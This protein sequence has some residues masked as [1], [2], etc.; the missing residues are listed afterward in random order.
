[1]FKLMN[2]HIYLSFITFKLAP[3]KPQAHQSGPTTKSTTNIAVASWGEGIVGTSSHELHS[4]GMVSSR[5]VQQEVKSSMDL[6]PSLK[7]KTP[8][9]NSNDDLRNDFSEVAPVLRQP[10]SETA[11]TTI[12]RYNT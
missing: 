10:S 8:D 1:M 7:P 5:G 4:K 11:A 3:V 12:Q 2:F 6:Y 9:Q